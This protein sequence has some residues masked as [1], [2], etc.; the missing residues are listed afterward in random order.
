MKPDT[1]RTDIRLAAKLSALLLLTACQPVLVT[2][3]APVEP[4][5]VTLLF[6]NPT[7]QLQMGQ[8][9]RLIAQVTDAAGQ[10]VD[11]ADVTFTVAGPDGSE[12]VRLAAAGDAQGTYRTQQRLDRGA[13][14]PAG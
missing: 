5:T 12:N 4:L 11:D 13:P 14:R 2:A 7:S 8:S 6:P 9:T 3:P 1:V 10:P